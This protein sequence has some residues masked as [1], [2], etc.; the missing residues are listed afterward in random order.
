MATLPNLFRLTVLAVLVTFL[1]QPAWFE[2]LLK[3]LV[4]ENAP[5]V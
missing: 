5:A 1:V 2:P 3:P 4:Q